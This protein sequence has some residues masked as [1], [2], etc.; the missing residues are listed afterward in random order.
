VSASRPRLPAAAR[1]ALFLGL[2]V[3]F[4]V[5]VDC[6]RWIRPA[7]LLDADPSWAPARL[8]LSLLVCAAAALAGAAAAGAFL[9]LSRLTVAAGP[10]RPL[11]LPAGVLAAVASASILL[12]VAL[13][14]AALDRV[15]DPM[16]VDDVS[17]I[18]P[19]LALSGA[20]ADFANATRDVPY[21]VARP[22]GSIG[23]LYLEA[24]RASLRLWGATVFGVRFPS[25]FAGAVSLVTAALLGRALLPAGGGAM[26]ALVLAGLRWH[27]I[28]SRWGWVMI[29]LAPIVDLATLLLIAARRR[30]NRG[31]ALVSGIVAGIGAHVYLSAWPAAAA[32]GLY[33]LWPLDSPETRKAR[34]PYG[35]AF[36]AG[37]LLAA[38]PL[39]VFH[40]GRQSPYFARTADHNVLLEISREKSLLPPIAAAADTLA[41]PWFL[42][43][44][45]PRQ[46]LPGRRRFPAFLGAAIAIAYGR[47]L[48]RPHDAVSALLLAH[49]VAVLAAVVAGGQADLPN[50]SRF[51]YLAS[52]CAVAVAAG[53]LWLVG[54]FPAQSRRAARIAALAAM[55]ALAVAGAFGAR[56][57]LALWPER[58]ETFG[59]FHGQDTLIGRAAARW[60]PYGSIQI[61]GGLGHSPLTI[62]AVRDYALDPDRR[63]ATQGKAPGFRRVRIRVVAPGTLPDG[64]ERVV[65]QIRDP[66]GVE[67][68]LVL[69]R[70]EGAR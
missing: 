36:G 2:L 70:R 22:F 18:R 66:W 61:E 53:V 16:W 27:L 56:D 46:D 32:L 19:T 40:A 37:F 48:L 17:L 60:A 44:P 23:V 49:A 65:E 38:A 8:L 58:P 11:R 5:A 33:A 42:S 67:W 21:G 52:I 62:E 9:L 50:G 15:S 29:V 25:A 41:A 28:L 3:S 4:V 12:G 13:R 63:A 68:G 26:A 14:F 59:S 54:L 31:L 6:A 57:A 47:A 30:R 45:T 39:F 34:V 24:Y 35:A 20:P 10:L 55:G 1:P 64:T 43:D 51:G 7:L 69:A